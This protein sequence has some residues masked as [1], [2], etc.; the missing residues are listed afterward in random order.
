MIKLSILICS[1]TKRQPLLL[2]LLKILQTQTNENIEIIID[3]DNGEKPIGKKRQELVQKATGEYVVFID[4]DDTVSENYIESILNALE[5]KPDCVGLSGVWI[6]NNRVK[7]KIFWGKKYTWQRKNGDCYIGTNHITPIKREIVLKT[8]FKNI[9]NGED[10]EFSKNVK[11]YLKTEVVIND[12]LYNYFCNPAH[13]DVNLAV[14]RH[15]K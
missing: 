1:I 11:K 7:C 6:E 13:T 5:T 4:D 14:L 12:V 9:C 15:G 8:G 3:T 10:Q 2:R